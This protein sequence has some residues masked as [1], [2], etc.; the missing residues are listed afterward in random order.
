MA[1]YRISEIVFHVEEDPVDGGYVAHALG[2]GI[3]TRVESV[4][5]LERMIRDVARCHFGRREDRPTVIRLIR[6]SDTA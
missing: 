5:E 6:S 4:A 1:T 3:T 2:Q